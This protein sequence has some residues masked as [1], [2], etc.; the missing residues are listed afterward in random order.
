MIALL[1][2]CPG[3][4]LLPVNPVV[5]YVFIEP[6]AGGAQKRLELVGIIGKVHP[7]FESRLE[8]Q[9]LLYRL[10]I[11]LDHSRMEDFERRIQTLTKR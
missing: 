3:V 1:E 9:Q 8:K 7:Y 5:P 6:A 4:K 2:Q 11:P 10:S